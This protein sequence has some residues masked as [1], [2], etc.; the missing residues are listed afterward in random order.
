MPKE[1]LDKQ[2]QI[3]FFST[4]FNEINIEDFIED[5]GMKS[6][7]RRASPLNLPDVAP[8]GAAGGAAGGPA[9]GGMGAPGGAAPGPP[10]TP[11]PLAG[12]P[13]PG[14]P[15]DLTGAPTPIGQGA[16]APLPPSSME[17]SPSDE[18]EQIEQLAKNMSKLKDTVTD[19]EQ[20]IRYKK[21]EEYVHQNVD[22][23]RRI[24]QDLRDRKIPI[25][26]SYDTEGV[27]RDKLYGMVT[28]V[29][30]K[31]L[32]DMFEEI[33]EYKFIASQVSRQF[34]DG[35]VADALVSVA[36]TVPR[37]GSRYDFK[38]EIPIL[39]GL[40]QYPQYMYR[41]LRIIPITKDQIQRELN[42]MSYRKMD[43]DLP[44][45]KEN[46]FSNIGENINRRQT[47]QKTYMTN[48]SRPYPSETPADHMWYTKQKNPYR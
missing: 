43:I 35:T 42:T 13:P 33:P 36:V 39:N 29:L 15:T 23:L 41:G 40:I 7:I 20:D 44:Y 6:R 4:I 19:L 47:D 12:G 27:Y 14:L 37:E 9:A 10:G 8:A 18:E 34:D 26:D 3:G 28:E 21:L 24:I 46:N 48:M 11:P 22:E 16:N 45:S 5:E 1:N 17:A 38:I 32:P 31:F 30:D 2:N 25:R